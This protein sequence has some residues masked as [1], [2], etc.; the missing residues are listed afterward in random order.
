MRLGMK[1]LGCVLRYS[2]RAVVAHFG[3]PTMKKLG[4][5]ISCTLRD[6]VKLAVIVFTHTG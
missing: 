1:M 4:R 2:Y 6:V 3:A 5:F